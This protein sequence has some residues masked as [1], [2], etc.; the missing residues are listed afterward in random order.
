MNL[1]AQEGDAHLREFMSTYLNN[2]GKFKEQLATKHRKKGFN[3][4]RIGS[5]SIIVESRILSS[6][7]EEGDDEAKRFVNVRFGVNSSE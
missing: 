5:N 4:A 2:N 3:P 6:L 7:F 1:D